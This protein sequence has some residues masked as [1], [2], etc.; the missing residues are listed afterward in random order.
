MKH[1][2]FSLRNFD[3]FIS[4]HVQALAVATA[5]IEQFKPVTP[6]EL[7]LVHERIH[8]Q[9]SF[10][11]MEFLYG[12]AMRVRVEDIISKPAN[13]I[14]AIMREIDRLPTKIQRT[15]KVLRAKITQL[16]A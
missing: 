1:G 14:S 5:L 15:I 6:T 11:Q 16:E 9:L 7:L 3:N 13:F 12:E 4:H 10:L 2:R 8:M